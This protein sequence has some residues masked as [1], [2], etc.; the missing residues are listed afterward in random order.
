MPEEDITDGIKF[1]NVDDIDLSK[2]EAGNI[3][4]ADELETLDKSDKV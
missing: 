3:S 1:G 2:E 4:V